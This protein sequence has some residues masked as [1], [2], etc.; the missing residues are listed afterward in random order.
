MLKLIVS[1]EA[2]THVSIPRRGHQPCLV[3]LRLRP[4]RSGLGFRR[5]IVRRLQPIWC[6]AVFFLLE[7]VAA[8]VVLIS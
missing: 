3:R 7:P 4:N 2:N 5:I 1:S 6:V 8:L